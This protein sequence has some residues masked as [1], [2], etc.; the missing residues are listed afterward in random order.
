MKRKALDLIFG[1]M[2][3]PIQMFAEV[4][5]STSST[6]LTTETAHTYW[7]TALIHLAAPK[8]VHDQFA[9]KTDI[10]SGNSKTI[11]FRKVSGLSTD[12]TAN[13]LA[14]GK[15]G[16]GQALTIT[17]I[18]ASVAQYGNYIKVTDML[19]LTAKDGI[20]KIS[21]RACSEQAA[22]VAD[23]I[24]RNKMH[25]CTSSFVAD[26]VAALSAIAATTYLTVDDLF[27]AAARLEANNAPTI[28]GSYIAIIH[29][30]VA[31][32]LM[33]SASGSTAWVDIKKYAD[34]D[35]IIDGEVGK[36]GKVRCVVTTNA[37]YYKAGD[38][39]GATST[40]PVFTTIVVGADA[41]G[42]TK[43][44]GGGL[45]LITHDKGEIGGPLNQFS[46]VGW[47]FTK[48]SEI[49]VDDYMVKIYSASSQGSLISAS[50]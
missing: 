41:Y 6:T 34:P 45:E 19:E 28:D 47:K 10:P 36:V 43:I 3:D 32:D 14:E 26:G 11:E 42:T 5:N 9:Q 20:M 22:G 25:E 1:R 31:K 38:L 49:L 48:A 17:P 35:S 8:L 4:V 16:D 30:F 40:V 50:N 18:T 13:T 2:F 12:I 33:S 46:T 44:T 27:K 39:S 37:K 7:Q 21:T 29:P 15:P 23:K 24:T